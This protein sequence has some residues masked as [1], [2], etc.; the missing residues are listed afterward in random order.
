MRA[1]GLTNVAEQAATPGQGDPL[2]IVIGI[3]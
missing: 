3:A 2:W 1:A